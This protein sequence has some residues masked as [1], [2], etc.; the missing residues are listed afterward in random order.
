MHVPHPQHSQPPEH[1][2]IRE[3]G[4]AAGGD[5]VTMPQK[6]THAVVDMGLNYLYG[7]ANEKSES[8]ALIRAAVERGVTLFDTA[9]AY[10]SLD[11]M[12]SE[13]LPKT[14]LP[15]G[16]RLQTLYI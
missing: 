5:L 11:S 10:G 4:E 3:D 7:Q 13:Y 1:N 16:R 12:Q 8:I 6:V 9:E 14:H 2:R 15:R